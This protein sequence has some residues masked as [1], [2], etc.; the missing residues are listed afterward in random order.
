MKLST[1]IT[2]FCI[3]SLASSASGNLVISQP[4]TY[5]LSEN[6]TG[7]TEGNP[8]V[9][10]T[11][12]SGTVNLSGYVTTDNFGVVCLNKSVNL[13][14]SQCAFKSTGNTATSGVMLLVQNPAYFVCHNCSFDCRGTQELGISVY[15]SYPTQTS[16]T[17]SIYLNT[18]Q[19]CR[20]AVQNNEVWGAGNVGYVYQNMIVN[21]LTSWQTD[22]ISIYYSAGIVVSDNFVEFMPESP[23]IAPNS[24]CI[25]AGDTDSNYNTVE[26][27]ICING[28]GGSISSAYTTSSGNYITGNTIHGIGAINPVSGSSW[29]AG[30]EALAGTFKNNTVAY[31]DW[32]YDML[33]DRYF[34][35]GVVASGNT[36]QGKAYIT[37]AQEQ[38]DFNAWY[39][40]VTTYG[41]GQTLGF[42]ALPPVTYPYNWP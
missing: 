39:T 35:S 29:S 36:W 25:Q 6:D 23:N 30:F 11:A 8:A 40:G 26:Y 15:G 19:D 28:G 12:T 17:Y 14:V 18:F 16:W 33:R 10:I 27:N 2:L 31:W 32:K 13:N 5:A 37:L 9:L 38:S 20:I 4:G 7:T 24:M 42:G 22:Q 21:G 3:L 41:G 1:I 34:G